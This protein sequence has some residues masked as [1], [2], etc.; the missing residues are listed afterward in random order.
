MA[1]NMGE[2]LGLEAQLANGFAVQARLLRSSRGCEL[3]VIHA[4]CVQSLRDGDF[5]LRVKEGVRK[6]FAL[7]RSGG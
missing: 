4:K 2:D 1:A 7:C 3:D 6:L 5:S